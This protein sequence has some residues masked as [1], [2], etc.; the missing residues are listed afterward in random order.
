MSDAGNARCHTTDGIASR[1]LAATPAKS[2]TAREFWDRLLYLVRLHRHIYLRE[3][4]ARGFALHGRRHG[5]WICLF[6]L[7]A[8]NHYD[9]AGRPN[10]RRIWNASNILG[11][12]GLAALGLPLVL[13][14]SL[15][16]VLAGLVLIGIGTFFAQAIATGFVGRAA[17]SNRGAASGLYLASYF[18]GGLIGSAALGQLFDRLGWAACVAGIGAA[19]AVA[20]MLARRLEISTASATQGS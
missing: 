17:T 12:A 2:G 15:G 13:L 16:A 4:C 18:F 10:G 3:F 14:P 1:G 6:R 7:L 8:L 11:R 19:L 5:A 20:A 9:A